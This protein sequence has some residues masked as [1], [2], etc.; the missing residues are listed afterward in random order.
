MTGRV[1]LSSTSTR[2]DPRRS[3][4]IGQQPAE[5]MCLTSDG[6]AVAPSVRVARETRSG[7]SGRIDGQYVPAF[8]RPGLHAILCGGMRGHLGHRG[9]TYRPRQ[10]PGSWPATITPP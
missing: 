8:P 2:V 10:R 1:E 9:L 4:G 6:R 3:A 7:R 5:P